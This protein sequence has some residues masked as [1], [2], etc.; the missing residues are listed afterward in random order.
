MIRGCVLL[1][2]K[3]DTTLVELRE[4]LEYRFTS[5]ASGIASSVSVSGSKKTLTAA[6]Q[7]REDVHLKR[8]AWQAA[9]PTLPDLLVF[10]DETGLDTAMVHRYGWGDCGDRVRGAV[11]Q[12]HWHTRTFVAALR[13][14]GLTAPMVISGPMDGA[15]QG[16]CAEVPLSG[17]CAGRH[18]GLGQPVF[19]PGRGCPRGHRGGRG[20]AEGRAAKSG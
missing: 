9:Q 6:E 2:A 20:H 18:R 8:E 16:V 5:P 14:R 13:Q 15:L 10:I 4:K 3:F 12:G 19:A 1:S 7:G 11:P 17:A